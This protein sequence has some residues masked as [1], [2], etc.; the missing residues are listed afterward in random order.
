MFS[1]VIYRGVTDREKV[2]IRIP[3]T[4]MVDGATAQRAGQYDSHTS[5]LSIQRPAGVRQR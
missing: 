3:V 4:M 2:F 5:L 1:F